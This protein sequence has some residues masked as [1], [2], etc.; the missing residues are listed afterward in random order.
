[1]LDQYNIFVIVLTE[2]GSVRLFVNGEIQLRDLA[3]LDGRIES[4]VA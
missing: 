3:A 1:L 4:L 2:I